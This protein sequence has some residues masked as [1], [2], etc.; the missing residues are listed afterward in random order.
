M[1]SAAGKEND[2]DSLSKRGDDE[3]AKMGFGGGVPG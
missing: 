2:S 3:A 1:V